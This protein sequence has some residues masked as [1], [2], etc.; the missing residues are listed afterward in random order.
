MEITTPNNYQVILK[1][2]FT[3]GDK[4]AIEGVLLEGIEVKADQKDFSLDASKM[5]A[6]KKVAVDLL[7]EE[8]SIADAV[9]KENIYDYIMDMPVTDGQFIM[10]A[11]DKITSGD[12]KNLQK[13]S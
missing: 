9:I 6:M 4:L 10:D 12:S 2:Q 11:I 5:S 13:Q 3:Y 1:D 7:V 8:I